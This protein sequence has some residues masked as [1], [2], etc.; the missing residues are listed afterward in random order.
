[1]PSSRPTLTRVT[2]VAVASPLRLA[3]EAGLAVA[4]RGGNALDAALT[5]A[6]VLA[7]A[8]PH[9]CAIGGDLLAL[10]RD[11]DGTRHVRQRVGPSPAR[12]RR[13]TRSGASTPS[14]RS[15][16]RI[17]VT[18]PGLVDGW[19]TL[20]GHGA[21]LPWADLLAPAVAAAADGVPVSPGLAEAV[22]ESLPE[23]DDFPDLRALLCPDGTPLA[24]RRPVPPARTRPVTGHACRAGAGR[25]LPRRP[26]RDAER[27]ARGA[28]RPAVDATTCVSSAPTRRHALQLPIDGWTL[29]AGRPE[30]A[31][32]PGAA[33]CSGRSTPS[34]PGDAPLHRR[35]S[36]AQLAVAFLH[37]LRRSGTRCWRTR[38]S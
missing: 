20:A 24:G 14:C 17:P 33:G 9:N 19:A 31:G 26:G 12:R 35:I 28:R 25:P 38:A 5:T 4:E 16:V 6:G 32:V 10:V 13:R 8:Y 3:T 37:L 21:A 27:G 2:R 7:V 23:L 22:A 15:A 30:L 29:F 36:T 11:P 34:M 1:M 18:F